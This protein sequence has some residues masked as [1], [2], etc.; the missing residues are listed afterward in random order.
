VP[1]ATRR[2][3]ADAD[4]STLLH[5]ERYDWSHIPNLDAFFARLYVYF[6]DKGF[7]CTLVRKATQ[8]L[9]SASLRAHARAHAAAGEPC[10]EPGD[11]GVHHPVQRLPA[12]VH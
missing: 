8:G 1:T 5:Q 12:A 4:G 7:A 3:G 11:A 6:T 10:F 2:L 9:L